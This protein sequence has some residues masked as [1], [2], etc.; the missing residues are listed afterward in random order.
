MGC[1]QAKQAAAPLRPTVDRAHDSSA[2]T[3]R[4]EPGAVAW[5]P[6]DAGSASPP[7]LHSAAD[8][9]LEAGTP[10]QPLGAA[11]ALCS[12]LRALGPPAADAAADA[13]SPPFPRLGVSLALLQLLAPLVP[14]GASTADAC[15]TLFKPLTA[16]ARSSLADCLARLE[17]SDPTSGL[18][19]AAAATVFASHAWRYEFALLLGAVE[20]FAAAQPRP[21]R[22][23][24]WFDC[25]VVNQH[26]TA[27][28][29]QDWWST[30]FAAGIRAIG[31]TCLVLAPWRDPIPLKRAWCLWELVRSPHRPAHAAPPVPHPRTARAP[32]HAPPRRT[33]HC[34][35]VAAGDGRER[36]AADGAA[37][38]D[39]GGGVCGGAREGL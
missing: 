14:A 13:A 38:A 8:A 26:A 17:A 30:A 29:P 27:A 9:G 3:A 33:P 39:R 35:S 22:V 5:H 20:A 21:E 28:L 1:G 16:R 37:A 32:P 6:P 11:E 23:Y 15:S 34:A 19:Y 36:G 12:R 2:S 7:H 10:Q 4:P 31:H 24:V 18:P 25:A